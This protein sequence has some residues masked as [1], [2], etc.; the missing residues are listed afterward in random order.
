MKRIGLT[1]LAIVGALL[2]LIVCRFLYLDR[3]I[4]Y[5]DGHAKLDYGQKLEASHLPAQKPDPAEFP[6]ETI[7]GSSEDEEEDGSVLAQLNGYYVSTTMLA[8]DVDAV[9][10]ALTEDTE[11]NAVLIDVKS[12]YGNFYY[13]S[14]LSGAQKATADIEAIDKLIAQLTARKGLTVIARVPAFSDPNYALAHQSQGLPL[15]SGALW[16]DD[17][18]CYWMNP[19]SNDVQGWLTSIAME[20]EGLGF[21]EVLFDDFYFPDSDRISWVS[22]NVTK[23]AAILD[24][25]ENIADNLSG[26]EIRVS[27]G[28]GD[29]KIAEN[30]ARLFID[31][32]KASDVKKYMESLSEAL[33]DPAAQLVFCTTSRDTRFNQC[34]VIRPLLDVE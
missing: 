22:D 30:A 20:L 7:L 4:V 9:R 19:Y 5:A 24:A 15:Y 18:G 26:S 31:T 23:E 32:E 28:T 27:F 11:Y 8:K 29:A 25:A 2:L 33:P 34:G 10:A 16:T 17:N 14:K 12:V 3:F 6:F 13:S 1:L 21:D